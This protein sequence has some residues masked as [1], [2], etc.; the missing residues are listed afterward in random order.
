MRQDVKRTAAN[1]AHKKNVKQTVKKVKNAKTVAAKDVSSA[2]ATIDKAAKKG[3]IHKNK[4][5]RLKS[6]VAKAQKSS[7]A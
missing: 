5:A 2:Y 1:A 6:R 3:V 4:A 7:K